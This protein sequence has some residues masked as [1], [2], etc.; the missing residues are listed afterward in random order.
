VSLPAWLKVQGPEKPLRMPGWVAV[1][2][3][4]S[5]L[6][7][8][9]FLLVAHTF[10][11]GDITV[12]TTT[13]GLLAVLLLLPLAPRIRRV[14]AGGVEAEIGPREAQRLQA[15]AAELPPAP[16]PTVE[17]PSSAP[18]VQELIQRD[19]P[20]G[21]AKLRIDL[22]REVR[23][24][25]TR[26]LRDTPRRPLSLGPM[27]RELSARGVLPPEVVAPLMDVYG[28][29]SRAVHGE[30]VPRDVAEE[31]ADVGLRLLSALRD[32]NDSSPPSS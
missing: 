20:L 17:Q 24:L 10:N 14:S 2:A 25:Y 3:Y 28:L 9:L 19:P 32:L 21:L 22:E 31:I 16:A 1:S 8:T 27:T 29:A 4:V 5:V 11:I 26:E 6:L 18:T 7:A 30:Y 15:A 23:D 13:L 12:D